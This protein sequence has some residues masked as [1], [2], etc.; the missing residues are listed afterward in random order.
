MDSQEREVVVEVPA[1][2]NPG[3]TP[4]Q[5]KELIQLVVTMIPQVIAAVAAIIGI[6]KRPT[7]VVLLAI[8]LGLGLFGCDA[9]LAVGADWQQPGLVGAAVVRCPAGGCVTITSEAIAPNIGQPGMRLETEVR[10][11]GE[12]RIRRGIVRRVLA[13]ILRR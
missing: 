3:L 7:A 11:D 6:F 10:S 1:Y 13:R 2:G 12:L 4:E 9:N 5:W 8:L